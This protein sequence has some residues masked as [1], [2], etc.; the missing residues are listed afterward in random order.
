MLTYY[1]TIE[2]YIFDLQM[3]ANVFLISM[4]NA[5]MQRY[6]QATRKDINE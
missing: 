2:K 1:K 4:K 5:N 3:K 6:L